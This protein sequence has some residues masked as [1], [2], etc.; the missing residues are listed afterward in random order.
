[1]TFKFAKKFQAFPIA[2][3]AVSNTGTT[4]E[5]HNQE[6]MGSDDALSLWEADNTAYSTGSLKHVTPPRLVALK[7]LL[8]DTRSQQRSIRKQRRLTNLVGAFQVFLR[9]LL[10]W[11]PPARNKFDEWKAQNQNAKAELTQWLDISDRASQLKEVQDES[12]QHFWNALAEVTAEYSSSK[13]KIWDIESYEENTNDRSA[14]AFNY[15]RSAAKIKADTGSGNMVYDSEPVPHI[16]NNDGPGLWFHRGFLLLHDKEDFA[17][18]RYEDLKVY[19]G[20]NEF[21]E[22]EKLPPDARVIGQTWTYCNKDGSPDKRYKENPA[23]PVCEYLRLHITS[24]TGLKETWL[25]SNTQMA[26]RLITAILGLRLSAGHAHRI[27]DYA[28]TLANIPNLS[29]HD[30]VKSLYPYCY[31]RD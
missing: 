16:T 28:K 30:A 26:F 6:G 20:Y 19:I 5:F 24:Q 13:T 8:V 23:L 11:L 10:F 14:S 3:V 7:R 29:V 17:L 15:E 4:V 31:D 25:F 2:H 1:M 18:L 27:P 21:V 12:S 22:T 9:G